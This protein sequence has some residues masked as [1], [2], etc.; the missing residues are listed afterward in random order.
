MTGL[1]RTVFGVDSPQAV[2]APNVIETTPPTNVASRHAPLLVGLACFIAGAVFWHLVG[3]WGF[4]AQV[5]FN[6]DEAKSPTRLINLDAARAVKSADA[7]KLE[8]PGSPGA[9][10]VARTA[11]ADDRRDPLSDLL[12]CT[13]ARRGSSA[14]GAGRTS[15]VEAGGPAGGDATTDTS[16]A[17]A[18]VVACPPLRRRLPHGGVTAE[19]ADRQMDARE[20]AERLRNGWDTGVSRIETGSLR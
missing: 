13:E 1:F 2:R 10:G 7:T 16:A 6:Q 20:A 17:A 5:A 3:F 4:V 19:R 9:A 15:E 18:L 11:T 12:Q 8:R 14:R